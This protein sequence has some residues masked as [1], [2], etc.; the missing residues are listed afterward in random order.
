MST[1]QQQKH[2]ILQLLISIASVASSQGRKELVER[3]KAAA[4]HLTEEKLVVVIAGEFK[5]GKSSLANALLDEPDL[6]PVDV[7]V[8]TSLVTSIA[9]GEREK[10]TVI[11]GEPGSEKAREITRAEI[12]DYVTEQRNRG[13]RRQARLLAIQS[14]NPRLRDGLALVD[15]PGVGSLNVSHTD[16]TY[17]YL[18]NADAIL[19]V[20]DAHRPLTAEELKFVADRIARHCRNVIY[21]VTKK[22]A[23]GNYRE[24]V[25]NNRE[26]LAA[27]LDC[28]GDEI[29]I[30]AV[31]SHLKLSYLKSRDEEDLAESNF[32][33]LESELWRLLNDQRGQILLSRALVEAGRAVAEMKAP[34]QTELD[35]HRQTSKKELDA[36]EAQHQQARERLQTLLENDAEWR[37]HLSRGLAGVR[38]QVHN[39]FQEGF[40]QVRRQAAEYLDEVRL[41]KSPEQIAGLVEVDVDALVTELGRTLNE[42]AAAVHGRIEAETGLAIDLFKSGPLKAERPEF[43]GGEIKRKGGAMDKVLN[44]GRAGSWAMGAMTFLGAMFGGVAGGAVGVFA[45]GVGA[46]PGAILGAQFGGLLGGVAGSA[47]GVKRGLSSLREQD[48]PEITR[49]VNRFIEDCQRLSHK[50]L[51]EATTEMEHFQQDELMG[52]IRREKKSCDQTLKSIQDARKL[53]EEQARRRAAELLAPLEQLEQLRRRVEQLAEAIVNLPVRPAARRPAT[54]PTPKRPEPARARSMN[55]AGNVSGDASGAQYADKGE[56]ADG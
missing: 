26:K 6:F 51:Q 7:D 28:R 9:Y 25:E 49:L 11:T 18:P 29:A 32:A 43:H 54:P 52:R 44:V 56:W 35:A 27:A 46:L 5:Q 13:N 45:G 40:V 38:H 4:D 12:A 48:K 20:S 24:I 17:A 2:N 55:V 36:L 15:T 34:L 23:A 22:D 53:S 50:T 39:D 33:A 42:G 3:L 14:P 41:L 1:Y 37:T 8:T 19:F 47:V 31:S 16:I 10:V 21:V 30:V